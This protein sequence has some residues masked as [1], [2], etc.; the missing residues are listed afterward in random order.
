MEENKELF[1]K[2][3]AA[4]VPEQSQP[5]PP[6]GD[7]EQTTATAQQDPFVGG[8]EPGAQA[9]TP[10]GEAAPY[11]LAAPPPPAEAPWSFGKKPPR[12]KTGIGGFFAIF[13]GVFALCIALLVATLFLGEG[14]FQI[15]KTLHSE[16]VIYVRED[17]GT[18]GLL[19]PN[20]AADVVRKSTVTVSVTTASGAGVTSATGADSPFPA[21]F[22]AAFSA[23]LAAFFSAF[24]R[25]I[26]A[27]SSSRPE[28]SAERMRHL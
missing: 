21:A 13:G 1:E 25:S 15:I 12:K 5:L 26:S 20:E 11:F 8:D 14:G 2:Q 7:G 23:F 19:T 18:S 3:N 27:S 6:E 16:R 17:D 4:P 24:S 28:I 9:P 22:F 10:E